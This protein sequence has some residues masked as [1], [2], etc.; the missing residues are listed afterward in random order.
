MSQLNNLVVV[1]Y[2]VINSHKTDCLFLNVIYRFVHVKIKLLKCC[3]SKF[4][5]YLIT[6]E[7]LN[8]KWRNIIAIFLVDI[9]IHFFPLIFKSVD[10]EF[11]LPTDFVR[12]TDK[13][14]NK[15]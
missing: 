2:T 10:D 5:K 13:V 8:I 14:I 7:I 6:P 11:Q 4:S 15:V 1:S 3:L 12:I 9:C